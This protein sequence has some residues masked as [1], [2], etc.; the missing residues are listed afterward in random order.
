MNVLHRQVELLP[1]KCSDFTE[2]LRRRQK[3]MTASTL[4]Y[5]YASIG[6]SRALCDLPVKWFPVKGES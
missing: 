1:A 3:N 4:N 5:Y 6:D 2:Q